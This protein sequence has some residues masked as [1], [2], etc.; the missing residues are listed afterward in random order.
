MK[1]IAHSRKLLRARSAGQ[2][3]TEFAMIATVLF[4]LM[5]GLM[6]LGSAVYSYNTISSA[7]R[8]A[9]RYAAVH[10]ATS[11]DPA[12][13]AGDTRIQQKALDYAQGVK[14]ALTDVT[15]SWPADPNPRMKLPDAQVQISYTY[16]LKIPF[17]S[18]VA[19]ALTS[20]SRMLVSQ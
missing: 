12:T 13:G 4:L 20:T 1:A 15:V 19:L 6:T 14:L 7:A 10:S 9:V 8:E 11:L 5:F 3:A 2:A 18:P 17:M 16:N